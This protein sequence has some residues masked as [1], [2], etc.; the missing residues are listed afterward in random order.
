MG[1]DGVQIVHPD[2]GE[3]KQPAGSGEVVVGDGDGAFGFHLP[4]D[5][6][7]FVIVEAGT[8][9][10]DDEEDFFSSGEKA[11]NGRF[12][13]V[14]GAHAE[15]DVFIGSHFGEEAVGAGMGEGVFGSDFEDNLLVI[16][17][18]ISREV[19][20]IFRAEDDSVGECGIMD[21]FL[22]FGA[23]H[24]VDGGVGIVPGV[25]FASGEGGGNDGMLIDSGPCDESAEMTEEFVWIR[26]VAENQ[27]LLGI[28]VDEDSPG[29]S[30]QSFGHKSLSFL[31]GRAV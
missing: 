17:E 23:F 5:E 16:A 19:Q 31:R 21:F 27:I 11:Q 6:V 28:H 10:V 30:P 4:E 8:D 22:S 20:A 9:G 15:G 26:T 25:V 24:A 18:E 12:Q 14:L 3:S 29:F 1:G 13:G 2:A 7:F